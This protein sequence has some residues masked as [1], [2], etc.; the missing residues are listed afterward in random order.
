M[1]VRW[2]FVDPITSATYQFHVNPNAGGSP[3]YKKHIESQSTTAPGGNVLLFEGSDEPKTGSISGTILELAHYQALVDWW[4][5]RYSITMTDD[6][7]RSQ[8]IYITEFLPERQRAAS[9]IYKH[10]FTMNY[11]VLSTNDL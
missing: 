10:S 7:G 2:T 4:E 8:V 5:K 9:H 6:I 3:Q 11:V 1:T